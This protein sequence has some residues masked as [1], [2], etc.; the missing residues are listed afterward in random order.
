MDAVFRPSRF[1]DGK[2]LAFADVDVANGVIVRGFRIVRNDGGTFAAVP[3]RGVSAGGETR[4]YPQV[5][6]ASTE[7]R[8]RFLG[9]LLEAYQRWT[10]DLERDEKEVSGEVELTSA[11]G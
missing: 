7:I 4:Y 9:R 8:D 5:S 11:S 1:K 2:I 10:K 3:S 6:F